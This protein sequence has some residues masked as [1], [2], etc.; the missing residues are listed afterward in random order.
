MLIPVIMAAGS[1]MAKLTKRDKTVSPAGNASI[2]M[3]VGE[4]HALENPG[5]IPLDIIEIQTGSYLGEDDIVR[6]ED[7]YG[8]GGR[9]SK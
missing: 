9:A 6:F 8:R 3:P 2:Y 1:G 4:V 5:V 7:R